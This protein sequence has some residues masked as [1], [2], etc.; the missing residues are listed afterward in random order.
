MARAIRTPSGACGPGALAERLKD[1]AETLDRAVPLVKP[2][3]RIAY[4]TCSVLDDEN[5]AQVKAFVARH[6]EFAILPPADVMNALGER[7][8]LFRRAVLALDRRPA[9]DTAPHRH[10]RIFRERAAADRLSSPR[11]HRCE[12]RD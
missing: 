2:G 4:V 3:G 7:A 10:R 12:S 11:R 1:Q 8:F 9:D 5:G 6:P